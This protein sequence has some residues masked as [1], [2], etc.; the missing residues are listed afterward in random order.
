MSYL[1]LECLQE[2]SHGNR[3]WHTPIYEKEND[4]KSNYF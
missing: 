4:K 2:N 1:G 3:L